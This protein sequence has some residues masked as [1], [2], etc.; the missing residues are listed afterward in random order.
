MEKVKIMIQSL[1]NDLD[2]G[3]IYAYAE[4][5]VAQY[6]YK[7]TAVDFYTIQFHCSIKQLSNSHA[8]KP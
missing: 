4:S 5:K 1:T 2:A 3:S 6:S 7:K 8:P